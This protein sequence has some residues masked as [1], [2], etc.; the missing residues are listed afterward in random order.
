[1]HSLVPFDTSHSLGFITTI[2]YVF[3]AENMVDTLRLDLLIPTS[4]LYNNDNP[5]VAQLME[6]ISQAIPLTPGNLLDGSGA[7][8][9]GSGA[10]PTGNNKADGGIFNTDAQSQNTSVKKNTVGI[11]VGIAGAAAAYGAAMFFI[12]RRYKKRRQSHRRSSSVISHSEMRQSSSPALMG[13]AHPYIS[14]GRSSPGGEGSTPN[15]RNSRG[16]GRTGGSARTQ[17]ISAPMMAENSLGWN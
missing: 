16:S 9:T 6:Y 4:K 7:S 2:A 1:M 11:T 12:A 15:D 10:S 8:G 5:S 3:I 17:Q 14:G 13:G